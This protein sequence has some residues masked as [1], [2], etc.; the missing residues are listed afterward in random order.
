MRKNAFLCA[1]RANSN[2]TKSCT[3]TYA[4]YT[5]THTIACRESLVSMY[6]CRF[7]V[8]VFICISAGVSVLCCARTTSYC[9]NTTKRIKKQQ[10]VWTEKLKKKKNRMW[11]LFGSHHNLYALHTHTLAR[12]H[13]NEWRNFC[14]SISAEQRRKRRRRRS[15]KKIA[16]SKLSTL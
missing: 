12:T 9:T 14:L 8:C 11:W 7:Y 1:H 3:H 2:P 15:R 10:F 5:R 16:T 6:W 4:Q 13:I